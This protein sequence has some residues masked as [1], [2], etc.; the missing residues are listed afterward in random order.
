MVEQALRARLVELRA[1]EEARLER[2]KLAR[3]KERI[4]RRNA[5]MAGSS[6][7]G[8]ASKRARMMG[9]EGTSASAGS[10]KGIDA[11]AEFLPEDVGGDGDG[12]DGDDGPRLSKEVRELM[13]K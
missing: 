12:E 2:L 13:A 7:F 3:E 4:R 9:K 10:S 6:A 5:R 8:V 1:T 11:D